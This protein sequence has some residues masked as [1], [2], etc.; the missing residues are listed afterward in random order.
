M[1]KPRRFCIILTKCTL[2]VKYK[3]GKFQK[4]E[5][6]PFKLTTT[7]KCVRFPDNHTLL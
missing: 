5:L 3:D 4:F 6:Y 2:N 1:D 7:V